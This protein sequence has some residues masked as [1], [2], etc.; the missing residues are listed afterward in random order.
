MAAVIGGDPGP[1]TK[2]SAEQPLRILLLAPFPPHGDGLHG[3]ARAVAGLVRSLAA[4][5]HVAL[6]Y[7]RAADEGPADAVLREVCDL[8]VEVP[9]DEPRGRGR[10]RIVQQLRNALGLLRGR[11][12]WVS[13]WSSAALSVRARRLLREWAPDIVQMEF[14]VM[15]RFLNVLGTTR[16]PVVLT[17]HDPGYASAREAATGRG[18]LVARL[19]ARAWRRFERSTLGRVD[20]AVA[21]TG[22][23]TAELRA[24]HAGADI[25][26]IPLGHPLPETAA[27]PTGRGA[28]SILFVG[29]FAHP[30]NRDAAHWLADA[31]LPRVRATVRDAALLLVGDGAPAVDPATEGLEVT[32]RVPDVWP[33]LDDAAVVAV[34]VRL[35]G[36]MRVK[37]LEALAA[38]KA[39][40]ATRRAAEGLDVVHGRQLFLADS[41]AD[42]ADALVRLLQ[43]AELR[44]RLAGEARTWSQERMGWDR[45]AAEYE[46][47]YRRLLAGRRAGEGAG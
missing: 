24:V 17:V 23:D 27:S 28:P 22:R 45:T 6:L 1:G 34:P 29:N 31:I 33:Y 41:E 39:V 7:L 14:E 42:F 36:G 19:D 35:G 18:G 10:G 37:L 47:L 21:F 8:A 46:R 15:G 2:P 40:V 25:T 44:A 13:K 9:R 16:A 11:P 26:T 5:H 20:A 12:V 43:D 30:P 4:S 3:G 32:G 38:G